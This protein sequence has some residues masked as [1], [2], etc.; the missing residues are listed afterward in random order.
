[1]RA[2]AEYNPL[3]VFVHF[4]AVIVVAMFIPNPILLVEV[5]IG[6]IV[7]YKIIFGKITGKTILL[8]SV[9]FL[10]MTLI[11]PLF[12]HNGVTVLFFLNGQA[13][14]LE[15][16]LYGMNNALMILS[17]FIAFLSFSE[18]MTVDK[19]MYLFGKISPKI[20]LFLSLTLRYIPMLRR[21][22]KK[23]SDT[24][25]T[26]GMY[27]E[28]NVVDGFK[29]TMSIFSALVTW[30][31]EMSVSTADAFYARGGELKN[32]KSFSFFRISK[33][34]VFMIVFFAILFGTVLFVQSKGGLKTEF[35]PSFSLPTNTPDTWTAYS[36]YAVLVL[37][38]IVC[39]VL[40][41]RKR[42]RAFLW[43]C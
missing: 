3:T 4:M 35:Y 5:L 24:Q 26:L 9:L 34:D 17:V 18:I 25:H 36:L 37:F 28:N 13:I 11:N 22:A 7:F 41:N 20:A 39:T 1:M 29:S 14:T 10:G 40:G 38:P 16:L 31:I 12:S 19:I 8:W 43:N 42:K 23:I 15:A 33:T 32:R 27:K 6:S 2:F 30:S 21:Q